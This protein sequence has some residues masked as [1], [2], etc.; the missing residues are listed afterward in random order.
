[1]SPIALLGIVVVLCCVAFVIFGVPALRKLGGKAG[2]L[3]F[4]GD[5]GRP[6]RPEYSLAE[7]RLQEARYAEAVA[8]YRKI[9]VQ[10]PHD[11]YVHV[12]IAAIAADHLNDLATAEVELLTACAKATAAD[13]LVLAHNRFA[14]LYQFKLQ[15]PARAVQIM[16]ELR[17]K[18]PGTT[19]AQRAEERITAL[20]VVQG[21][22]LPAKPP[23]KIAFRKMDDETRQQ[24]RG[25]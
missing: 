19:A 6:A 16:E 18:L 2:G 12:Q 11:V 15:N 9:G 8:E 13:T 23:A 17:A 4:P 21:G 22:T 10:Y 1:M 14:D 25:S 20:K 7:A 3:F 24:R 5:D